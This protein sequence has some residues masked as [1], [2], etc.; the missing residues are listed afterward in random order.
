MN[1]PPVAV[2]QRWVVKTALAHHHMSA[3][4]PKHYGAAAV[5][6][7]SRFDVEIDEAH[8]DPDNV[9]MSITTRGWSFRFGLSTRADVPRMLL[10]LRKHTGSLVFS[11]VAVGSFRGA[12]VFLVKDREF[13]DRFWLRAH[14]DGQMVEFVPAADDLAQ[15]T[16]AVA[17][18]VQDL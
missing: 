2:A 18:A 1:Q 9:Q 3:I 4:P 6:G 7:T 15:F 11:E 13:A 10:F 14:G 16:D 17:Q 5:G 12:S 8:D